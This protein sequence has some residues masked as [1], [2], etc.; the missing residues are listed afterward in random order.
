MTEKELLAKQKQLTE[1]YDNL[2]K[3]RQQHLTEAEN[4]QIEMTKL[5][6]Q[7]ALTEELLVKTREPKVEVKEKK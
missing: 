5:Q 6:G 1:Q 7:Y 4:N 2:S 3:Q